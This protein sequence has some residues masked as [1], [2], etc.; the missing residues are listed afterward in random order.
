METTNKQNGMETGE[1]AVKSL[2]LRIV[3]SELINDDDK[4]MIKDIYKN[5]LGEF[6]SKRLYDNLTVEELKTAERIAKDFVESR[7]SAE[8]EFCYRVWVKSCYEGE[9]ADRV[10]ENLG[11]YERVFTEKSDVDE[12]M[13]KVVEDL[14]NEGHHPFESV[15]KYYDCVVMDS[16]IVLNW[17]N[18]KLW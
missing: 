12:Y 10:V 16:T 15:D 3:F 18:V 6:M 8:H 13:E 7:E 5:K 17:N 1:P 14:K 4:K 9:D 2:N 11:M